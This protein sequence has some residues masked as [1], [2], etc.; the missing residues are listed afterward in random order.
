MISEA[1]LLF[2]AAQTGYLDGPRV[3]ASMAN[4]SWFPRRFA[5]LSDRLVTQNGVFFMGISAIIIILI[6]QGS[7]MIL[8]VLY[9]INVFITFALSQT[10]M[11]RHWWLE[12][13]TEKRWK[14]K[15]LINGSRFNLNTF[16]FNNCYNYKVRGRWMDNFVNY[17][18]A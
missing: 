7:V 18:I 10:G 14:R 6:T 1:A 11:V 5:V 16:Y 2:V 9:S 17:F 13:K 15:L 12:R 8:L 3:I 4:D